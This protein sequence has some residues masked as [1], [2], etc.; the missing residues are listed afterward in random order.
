VASYGWWRE[1]TLAYLIPAWV[2]GMLQTLRKFVDHLGLPAGEALA[3]CR[4][5]VSRSLRGR[6]V[7]WTSFDISVHGL[8]HRFPQMPH[9]NLARAT[10]L[11]DGNCA[12]PVFT[13]HLAAFR[14]M[15]PHLRY[16]GIG[17]NARPATTPGTSA[18]LEV[19]T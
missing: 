14:H 16:P 17:V 3:G 10:E 15:L 8:H 2:T 12:A 5:V 13:S 1:F 7:D 19:P 6:F 9:R 18:P 4:T 11:L